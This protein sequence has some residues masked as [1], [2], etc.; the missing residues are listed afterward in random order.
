MLF[1]MCLATR[2]MLATQ[3]VF[4]SSSVPCRKI[5]FK[6]FHQPCILMADLMV[7]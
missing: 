4:N 6:G 3:L 7:A 1:A 2:C 5:S